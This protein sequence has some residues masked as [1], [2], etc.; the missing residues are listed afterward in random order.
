[1]ILVGEVLAGLP[2]ENSSSSKLSL[3]PPTS[4]VFNKSAT[5]LEPV[6]PTSTIFT[7]H[8][9]KWVSEEYSP[10]EILEDNSDKKV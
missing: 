9:S 6:L 1:M 10:R 3:N 2:G 4:S 5:S 8:Y 7:T